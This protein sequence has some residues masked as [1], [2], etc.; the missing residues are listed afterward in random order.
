[1]GGF[2]RVGF[3][4]I[5]QPSSSHCRLPITPSSYGGAAEAPSPLRRA[6]TAAT[7]P[8]SALD[9]PLVHTGHHTHDGG[10]ARAGRRWVQHVSPRWSR[11]LWAGDVRWVCSRAGWTGTPPQP[12]P[13]GSQ[14][15]CPASAASPN[16]DRLGDTPLH[17]AA[18]RP[19]HDGG[20][21]W[22]V[23]CCSEGAGNSGASLITRVFK[24][25]AQLSR[26]L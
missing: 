16:P 11:A 23:L 1:V 3:V 22:S 21:P 12:P 6:I 15:A 26:E 19:Q 7:H 24:A 14:A 4:R 13:P 10:S 2:G 5:D 9:A 18:R 25:V 17:T 8:L 20:T